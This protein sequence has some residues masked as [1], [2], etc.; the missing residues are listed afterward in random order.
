MSSTPPLPPP[1]PTE[2]VSSL[3]S[4]RPISIAS[5]Q[6]ISETNGA[7]SSS[8]EITGS[9]R[10][11]H[12]DVSVRDSSRPT[13]VGTD[14]ASESRVSIPPESPRTS[15]LDMTSA[16]LA[17]TNDVTMSL[18]S[19]NRSVNDSVHPE[20]FANSQLQIP[21][22]PPIEGATENNNTNK[23]NVHIMTPQEDFK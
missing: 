16:T 10:D 7:H 20:P 4:A 14:V 8:P 22:P 15:Q 2:S 17:S 9:P 23:N 11:S 6:P 19:I 13:S 21:P 12:V 5:D 3:N 18:T 1:P